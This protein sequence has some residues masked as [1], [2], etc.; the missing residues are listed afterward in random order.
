MLVTP[1]CFV[2]PKYNEYNIVHHKIGK[3]IPDSKHL[4][5]KMGYG[6]GI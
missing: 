2:I 1:K 4:S 3:T 5:N 6:R